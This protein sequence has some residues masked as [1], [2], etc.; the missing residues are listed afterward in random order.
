MHIDNTKKVN[1]GYIF[2]GFFAFFLGLIY[3]LNSLG[4]IIFA[5]NLWYLIPIFIISFGL[6]FLNSRNPGSIILTIGVFLLVMFSIIISLVA[7]AIAPRT[8]LSDMP[9]TI[10]KDEHATEANINID[11]LLGSLSISDGAHS[12]ILISGNLDLNSVKV[13][14]DS[15]MEDNLQS[16]KISSAG[17]AKLFGGDP[18]N[19]IDLGLNTEIPINLYLSAAASDNDI[20]LSRIQVKKVDINTAASNV[21]LKLPNS[22]ISSVSIKGGASSINLILPNDAGIMLDLASG[23]S[24]ETLTGFSRLNDNSYKSDNYQ[25]AAKKINIS[26]N[27]G[28]SSLSV[29]WYKPEVD[30]QEL[31][32]VQLF[33]YKQSEDKDI[34]CDKQFIKPVDRSIPLSNDLI[35]DTI[36]L[37]IKGQLTTDEREQGFTTEFPNKD[38]KLL[39]DE[40][41]DGVLNLTFSEV[42]GFTGGGSCRIMILTQQITKTASQFPGVEKVVYYP[43]SI[44]QP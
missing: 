18:K 25:S 31:T 8:T 19:Q 32:N 14:T 37:L 30:T 23:L 26:I 36:N 34:S 41:K 11:M 39:N 24:S 21:K 33:Y 1:L 43:E 6:S 38:F 2:F 15:K 42:P 16:V 29:E 28:M 4:V 35:K 44:F 20:D 13:E 27:T 12:N 17:S 3:L 7:S 9:M 40:L 10:L 22:A 5:V